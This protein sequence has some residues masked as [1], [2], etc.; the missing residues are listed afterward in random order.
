MGESE[1]QGDRTRPERLGGEITGVVYLKRLLFS[2]AVVGSACSLVL[3]RGTL[4][5]AVTATW[6]WPVMILEKLRWA[7]DLDLHPAFIG[8]LTLAVISVAAVR[9]MSSVLATSWFAFNALGGL[10]FLS[11]YDGH[12]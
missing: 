2:L 12:S 1:R 10:W 11:V 7:P 4:L 6:F 8:L 3:I 9:R 5:D